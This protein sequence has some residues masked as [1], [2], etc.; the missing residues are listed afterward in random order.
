MSTKI[1]LPTGVAVLTE[2]AARILRARRASTTATLVLPTQRQRAWQTV[3]ETG[4]LPVQ[5]EG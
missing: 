3:M 2:M 4:V 1:V 5:D